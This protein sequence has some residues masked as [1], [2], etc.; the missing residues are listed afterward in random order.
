MS[1][2]KGTLNDLSVFLFCEVFLCFLTYGALECCGFE[3]EIATAY[4]LGSGSRI[5]KG[6]GKCRGHLC[7]N[8]SDHSKKRSLA[9]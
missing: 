3:W 7:R 1:L 5:L 8:D 6:N 4:A 2:W 9:T